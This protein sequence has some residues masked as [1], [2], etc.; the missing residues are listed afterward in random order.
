MIKFRSKLEE[1]K[2]MM[3]SREGTLFTYALAY[4]LVTGIAPFLIITIVYM[5][6]YIYNVDQ[7]VNVFQRYIPSDLILPF[8]KYIKAAEMSSP[9]FIISLLGIS[10]WVAS[11]S[12]Y[13]FLLLSSEHDD[14][15]ISNFVLRLL[16]MVYFVLIILGVALVFFLIGYFPRLNSYVLPVLTFVFFLFVY[17]LLSFRYTR[18]SDVVY[19]ALFSSLSLAVLG[20]FFFRYINQY[21][22]YQTIYGPLSSLMIML[23]SAWFIAWVVY[24]GYVINYVF[25]HDNGQ[26]KEKDLLIQYLGNKPKE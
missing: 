5:G 13:S 15:P 25:R 2:T 24:C 18:F 26:V 3:T 17:R 19:G 9:W 6:T 1:V 4:S 10:I 21:S 20:R 23:I 11:K 16:A 7:I 8:V 14:I 22:N 12:V